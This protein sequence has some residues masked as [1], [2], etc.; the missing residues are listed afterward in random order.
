MLR[1][2]QFRDETGE[3]F[4]CVWKRLED[5]P[6]CWGVVARYGSRDAALRAKDDMESNQS[7]LGAAS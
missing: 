1:V 3:T 6:Q 5:D 7:A 2:V 4:W